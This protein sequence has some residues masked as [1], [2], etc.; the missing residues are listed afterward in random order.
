MKNIL[1]IVITGGP[2]AG[3][4]TALKYVRG[5][6]EDYGYEVITSEETAMFLIR[7][8]LIPKSDKGGNI[9][10]HEF[11]KLILDVQLTKE[12]LLFEAAENIY[13]DKVAVILDRGIL[14]N[15]AYIPHEE[16]QE[17]IDQKGITI[18]DILS[19]YDLIIHLVSTAKDKPEAYSKGNEGRLES[20]DEA[21]IVEDNTMNAW[22]ESENKYIITNDCD[23]EEKLRRI[24]EVI[25]SYLK[26]RDNS[27]VE[28]G[29]CLI[30]RL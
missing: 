27:K 11:Q 16:F 20:L 4:T 3:K 18:D 5:I 22:P 12:D 24:R 15:R 25:T 9:D 17:L 1:R 23:F 13:S 10:L 30:K 28:R 14:D 26:E 8:N 19:R 29:K 7:A 6:L 2:C 21:V